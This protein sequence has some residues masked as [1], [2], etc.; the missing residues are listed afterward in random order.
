MPSKHFPCIPGTLTNLKALSF[1]FFPLGG[2]PDELFGN[3]L[4]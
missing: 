3:Y 2:F 1:F 4:K